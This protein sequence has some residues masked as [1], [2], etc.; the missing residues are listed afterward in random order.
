MKILL[1]SRNKP[2]YIH[3]MLPFVYEQ[4]KSL[5][6]LGH[7][8]EYFRVEG[9]NFMMYFRQ[10]S[11]LQH[12]IDRFKPDVLHAHYGLSGIPAV[13]QTH[14]PTVITFHNGETLSVGVNFL[15]SLFSLK[16]NYMIYVAQHIY[17]KAIFKR[18]RNYTI[19]PCGVAPDECFVM[20]RLEIRKKWKMDED[21]KYILFG[22][23]FGNLR[24][25]YALLK[26]GIETLHRND[27]VTLEM[28]GFNRQQLTEL[29]N[30]CDLF[31][32]PSK[33]E[34]SPQ[35]LKEAMACNCPILATDIADVKHLLGDLEGHYICDFTTESIKDKLNEALN[36]KG[37]TKGRDRIIEL[38]Y[39]NEQVA[40][41]LEKIYKSIPKKN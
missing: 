25:N 1:V 21:K 22:G 30:A 3:Q 19:L 12:V 18:K 13:L 17:D 28:K 36:F 11:K 16:A 24:K 35:A 14:I 4:G 6:D 23:A 26:A 27:V 5:R 2:Q 34:G 8:V 9:D 10:G 29:M 7:E 40:M 20:D 39:T 32:L 41:S 38:G 31:A 37:R 33:S 15:C